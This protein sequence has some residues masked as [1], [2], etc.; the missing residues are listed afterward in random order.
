MNWLSII[1][2]A[3][4]VIVAVI[5]LVYKIKKDGLRK[6]AIEF[7]V[8]A[9]QKFEYGKNSAKFNY[10]FEAVY[11]LIPVWLKFIFTKPNVISFIQK[12]FKEIKVALDYQNTEN[13]G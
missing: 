6:V 8:M 13:K 1:I 12:T 11:N 2:I 9:E 4:A 7:I 5:F 10:V 3:V